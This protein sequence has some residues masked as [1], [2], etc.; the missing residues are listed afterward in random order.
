MLPPEG[1]GQSRTISVIFSPHGISYASLESYVASHLVKE[2]ALPLTALLHCFNNVSNPWWFGGNILLGA[3]A[4]TE[5]AVRL[6]ARTWIS[7]HDGDKDVRGYATGLLKTRK[8]DREEVL[9]QLQLSGPDSDLGATAT[10]KHSETQK[11]LGS[12]KWPEVISLGTG[13]EVQ[14][15]NGGVRGLVASSAASNPDTSDIDDARAASTLGAATTQ[16]PP[17]KA[18]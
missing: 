14:I 13:G 12:D 9:G 2:S 10:E 4:G 15:T 6:K 1:N 7:A 16:L 11:P 5:T 17:I 8:W 18:L 3:P